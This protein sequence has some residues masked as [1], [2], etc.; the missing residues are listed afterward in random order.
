ML[1]QNP[2]P[3][4]NQVAMIESQYESKRRIQ[5][6]SNNSS[7]LQ[8]RSPVRE[9]ESTPILYFHRHEQYKHSFKINEWK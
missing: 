6:P 4:F 2:K 9:R 5:P 8:N 3:Y 1:N 7:L